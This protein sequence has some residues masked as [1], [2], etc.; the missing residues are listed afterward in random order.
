M[1]SRPEMEAAIRRAAEAANPEL[2]EIKTGRRVKYH[3]EWRYVLGLNNVYHDDSW[4]EDNATDGLLLSPKGVARDGLVQTD[5]DE[6]TFVR[7]DVEQTN[8]G[9]EAAIEFGSVVAAVQASGANLTIVASKTPGRVLAAAYSNG[10]TVKFAF[11]ALLPL[12]G[13]TI[14]T[15][16]A[17]YQILKGNN[18]N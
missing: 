9:V 14:E 13:Q 17:I 6:E 12:S 10:R 5:G 3:G 16:S 15:V 2:L 8:E 1:P 11:D 7:F 18:A 4:D